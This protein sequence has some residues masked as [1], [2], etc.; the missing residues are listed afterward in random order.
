MKEQP[1][2]H[3]LHEELH[4]EEL[5]STREGLAEPPRRRNNVKKR[6]RFAVKKSNSEGESLS[7]EITGALPVGTPV[8]SHLTPSLSPWAS[9]R[10]GFHR[11]AAAN[12]WEY[13]HIEITLTSH[14]E[15]YTSSSSASH[16]TEYE[17]LQ[18]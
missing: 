4:S 17:T 3:C 18:I 15:P 10:N 7:T 1:I 13:Y 8:T 16:P 9:H 14:R 6:H 11:A 5:A 2:G 12:V